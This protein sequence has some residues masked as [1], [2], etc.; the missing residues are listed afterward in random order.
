MIDI[1]AGEVGST[2]N[3]IGNSR[4]ERSRLLSNFVNRPFEIDGQWMASVEGF[5]QGIKFPLYSRDRNRAFASSGSYAKKMSP[6]VK[7]LGVWLTTRASIGY[8]PLTVYGSYEHHL[9]IAR[10]LC[11]KF[12]QNPDCMAGLLATKGLTLTHDTGTPE[13]PD[14]SLPA[15]FFCEILTKIRDEKF[16]C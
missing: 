8:S 14:T 10:A 5:I 15:T 12:N 9:Q 4:D 2:F 11:N 3:I 16:Y 1:R 6:K 7:P 13:S